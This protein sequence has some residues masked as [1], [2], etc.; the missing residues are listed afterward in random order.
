VVL[1]YK[2]KDDI[3]AKLVAE[4]KETTHAGEQR[5]DFQ[6]ILND[7]AHDRLAL[8]VAQESIVLLK[9]DHNLL[10][11]DKVKLSRVLV[12]GPLAETVN[13]GGYSTGKPKFYVS[14]IAGIKSDFGLQASV[15][16]RPGCTLLGGTDGR[17]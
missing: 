13:L 10:P 9:N 15:D 12:V 3:F 1:N 6:A 5:P 14:A 7:P 16:Y 8:R 17:G 11:L 2:G 4:G